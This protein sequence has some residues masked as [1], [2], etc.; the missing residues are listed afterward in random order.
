MRLDNFNENS[1]IVINKGKESS[2]MLKHGYMGTEHLLIGLINENGQCSKILEESNVTEE[3]VLSFIKLY[4][5]IGE[6]NYSLDEVPFTPKLL[7]N[8]VIAFQDQST[9]Y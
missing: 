5:G 9:Y 4:V 1:K 6:V 3:K 8:M 7:R 2:L